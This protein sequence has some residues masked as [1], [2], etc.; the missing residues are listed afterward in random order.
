MWFYTALCIYHFTEKKAAHPSNKPTIIIVSLLAI[1]FALC[2]LLLFGYFGLLFE[3]GYAWILSSDFV[4]F[5]WKISFLNC[6]WKNK[7]TYIYIEVRKWN[8]ESIKWSNCNDQRASDGQWKIWIYM[9]WWNPNSIAIYPT[10][11]FSVNQ[12]INKAIP[13]SW[14]WEPRSWSHKCEF[15]RFNLF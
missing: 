1:I 13:W 14:A 9:C 6:W 7:S 15:M 11:L 4:R 10:W 12:V 3:Y 5:G 8:N 2:C